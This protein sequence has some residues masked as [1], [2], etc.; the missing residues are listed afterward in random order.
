MTIHSRIGASSMHRWAACPGSVKLSA[1]M[2][3]VKSFHAEEGTLAHDLAA[4]LINIELRGNDGGDIA[5]FQAKWKDID[6]EMLAHV[7]VY[8]D[9]FIEESKD[10]DLHFVE[11][12]FDL[13]QK[14]HPGLFGTNDASY[15]VKA[16]KTLSV[17]DFKY[18]QG[19]PVEVEE[20][21][22]LLYYAV[23][24]LM[25]LNLPCEWVELVICQPRYDHRDGPIRR[26][27][28]HSIELLDFIADLVEAAKKTE[29]PN[30]ELSPG[31]HCRFCPAVPICPKLENQALVAAKEQF[32]PV[33]PYDPEKLAKTLALIPQ[34]EAWIK[35][36][37]E[38]A[39]QECL[40]GRQPPGFKLVQRQAR[41]KWKDPESV[42]SALLL[43][44]GLDYTQVRE[45]APLKSPAQIEKLLK[46]D[47]KKLLE[48][49]T[50]KES[51]GLTLVPE[52]DKR[53]AAK[54]DAT[55]EFTVINDQGEPNV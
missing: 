17:W 36:I 43:E 20:N 49:L 52:S 30:A 34:I 19:I 3:N 6:N 13:S 35:G 16:T 25:E 55:T 21:E 33:L 1:D 45:T 37:E 50:V 39:Y 32:S 29:D 9:A 31:E 26:W 8:V 47:E 22:Q 42:E 14:L 12:K 40:A 51:S 23:G 5:E 18:G 4:D 38:F 53:P 24:A 54:P 7:G 10:A 46:K 27:K 44:L 2:P 28:I 11:K 15:Y 48:T 41:R